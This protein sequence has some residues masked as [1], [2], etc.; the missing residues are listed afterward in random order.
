MLEKRKEYKMRISLACF[1]S[2]F[3]DYF[4]YVVF[5]GEKGTEVTMKKRVFLGK[6]NVRGDK[7]EEGMFFMGLSF[8]ASFFS[9]GAEDEKCGTEQENDALKSRS[10]G[11]IETK[12]RKHE[13]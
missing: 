12:L 5:E 8:F 4:L 9:A 11:S 7:T 3:F 13:Q 1:F 10:S 6:E 2:S